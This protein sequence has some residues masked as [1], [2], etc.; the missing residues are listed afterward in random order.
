MS[1]GPF[2]SFER[3]ALL[4]SGCE[5][6]GCHR[7]LC[8]REPC[9]WIATAHLSLGSLVVQAL[10]WT[11]DCCCGGGVRAAFTCRLRVFGVCSGTVHFDFFWRKYKNIQN[12]F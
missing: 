7:H 12:T 11:R 8:D 1:H 4:L 6:F 2:I 3:L 10:P 9:G 5:R